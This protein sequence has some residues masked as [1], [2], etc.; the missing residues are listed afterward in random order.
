MNR[1]TTIAREGKWTPGSINVIKG[2]VDTGMVFIAAA[3]KGVTALAD[4]ND[5]DFSLDTK[6]VATHLECFLMLLNHAERY[7]R[8]ASEMLDH[9]EPI[10][11]VA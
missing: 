6:L 3:Q 4:L 5:T 1:N 10:G 11:D 2:E 7:A 8:S 9:V